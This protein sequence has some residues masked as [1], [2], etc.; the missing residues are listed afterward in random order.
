MHWKK[1]I[2]FK[3]HTNY[4]N[5]YSLL[6]NHVRVELEF[7]KK[8]ALTLFEKARKTENY[9]VKRR[10]VTKIPIDFKLATFNE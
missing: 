1:C 2:F 6:N 9:F 8:L 3:K 10:T 4:C 5:Y 7:I